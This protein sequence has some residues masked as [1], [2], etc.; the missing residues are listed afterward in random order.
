MIRLLICFICLSL[1]PV[2]AS[3]PYLRKKIKGREQSLTKVFFKKQKKFSKMICRPGV[4]QKFWKLVKSFRGEGFYI[5]KKLNGQ[6]D[7]QTIKKYIPELKNKIKWINIEIEKIKSKSSF[8]VPL[9]ETKAFNSDLEKLLILKERYYDTGDKKQ[10]RYIVRESREFYESFRL[11]VKMFLETLSFFHSYSFPVDHLNLRRRYDK[12]KGVQVANDKRLANEIYFYRKIVQDGTHG[13]GYTGADA[14]IRAMIDTLYLKLSTPNDFISED[15]RYDME[16]IFKRTSRQMNKGVKHFSKRLD[17]WSK[18]S[19][20]ALTF[21]RS[22]YSGKVKINNREEDSD[23]FVKKNNLARQRLKDFVMKLEAKT[24]RYW[25]QEPELYRSLFVLTTILFNEVGTVD[26]H[27]AL[28]RLDVLDI[29]MNRF[30]SKKYNYIGKRDHIYSYLGSSKKKLKHTPWLN[31]LFK[32]GEFSFTYYFITG[33]LRIFCPEMTR[34]GKRLRRKNL[35]LAIRQLKDSVKRFPG[36]RYFSRSSM[37][38]R[39]DMSSL[40]SDY[41][42]VKERPGTKIRNPKNLLK[43]YRRGNYRYLYHFE[44]E[45]EILYKVVEIGKSNY[46]LNGKTSTFYTHRNPHYF[47]YFQSIH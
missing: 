39:I 44:G 46:A 45:N 20:A 11:R 6:L 15:I 4:E 9:R 2:E 24:Y 35:S 25:S 26:G 36:I 32:E 41:V 13:K 31:V 23:Q 17:S 10:K 14:H 33:S 21:Y 28:E 43:R 16:A 37:L 12:Y 5:P 1:L 40:W 34:S 47:R 7:R 19:L 3:I 18:R 42:A 29:V 38:G 22:L 27:D 30:E 8:V